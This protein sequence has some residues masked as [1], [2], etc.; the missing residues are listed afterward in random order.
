MKPVKRQTEVLSN[1]IGP[2]SK[3]FAIQSFPS[4]HSQIN[5]TKPLE[6]KSQYFGNPEVL[7]SGILRKKGLFVKSERFVKLTSDG[8][9]SYSQKDTPLTEK[10]QIDLSH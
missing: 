6:T 10:K 7:L 1:N 8:V 2:A 5:T 3:S 4:F 9:L